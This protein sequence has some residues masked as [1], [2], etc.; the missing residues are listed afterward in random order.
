MQKVPRHPRPVVP[1]P[2]AAS[3]PSKGRESAPAAA[4]GHR[5]P[6][7]QA[8]HCGCTGAP[9]NR[10]KSHT[11]SSWTGCSSVGC[12]CSGGSGKARSQCIYV[13]SVSSQSQSAQLL[14][15]SPASPLCRGLPECRS[16]EGICGLQGQLRRDRTVSLVPLWMRSGGFI[17]GPP[18]ATQ[19][20]PLYPGVGVRLKACYP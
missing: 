16:T 5:P 10:T 15:S 14:H 8:Q 13:D 2:P 9:G 7:P 6:G 12:V 4:A 11:H 17:L 19:K 20:P 3:P 18:L 1:E